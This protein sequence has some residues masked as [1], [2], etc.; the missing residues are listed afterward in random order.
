MD[1]WEV[2]A[3]QQQILAGKDTSCHEGAFF[4]VEA[5][6]TKV[7]TAKLSSSTAEYRLGCIYLLLGC[8]QYVEAF[9]QVRISSYSAFHLTNL[10]WS[11]K[12]PFWTHTLKKN[13]DYNVSVIVLFLKHLYFPWTLR[14][15]YFL[16]QENAWHMA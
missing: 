11:C 14:D 16:L 13:K 7:I 15:M 3:W 5:V 8:M 10:T 1:A 2:V 12:A 4:K 9:Q 6:E